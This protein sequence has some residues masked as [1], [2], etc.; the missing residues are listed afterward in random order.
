V[1]VPPDHAP[2]GTATTVLAEADAGVMSTISATGV[3]TEMLVIVATA[4]RNVNTPP[5]AEVPAL[6]DH[7][8]PD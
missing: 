8:R 1:I 2:V 6:G 7:L 4:P 3:S 5:C